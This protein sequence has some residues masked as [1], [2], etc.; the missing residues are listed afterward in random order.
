MEVI[1][2]RGDLVGQTAVG[3]TYRNGNIGSPVHYATNNG[4]TINIYRVPEDNNV[5]IFLEFN[6]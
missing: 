1:V 5:Y 4:N 2:P 6:I 3:Y